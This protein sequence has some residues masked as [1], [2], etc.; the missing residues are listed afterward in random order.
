VDARLDVWISPELV[1]AGGGDWREDGFTASLTTRRVTRS[2]G[3]GQPTVP[4]RGRLRSDL[5]G[6][7]ALGRWERAFLDFD[8]I[9]TG[10]GPD[11]R[12]GTGDENVWTIVGPA[13][14][15]RG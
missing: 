5:A 2:D 3:L 1:E 15:K 10:S 7:G 11:L 13:T 12:F 4:C 14:L 9:C 6:S 8:L